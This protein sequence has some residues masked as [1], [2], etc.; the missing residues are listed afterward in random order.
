MR[1]Q[2]VVAGFAVDEIDYRVRR[3]EWVSLRRGAYVEREIHD[4]MTDV[5]R[6]LALIHAVVLSLDKPAV[7]S[8]VSAAILRGLPTWDADLSDAA[9]YF[10]TSGCR[11]LTCS[12]S[13]TLRTAR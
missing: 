9:C 10:T 2:A 8:H 11:R 4:A 1:S 6:H 3:R 13:S 5:E 12:V 7:V